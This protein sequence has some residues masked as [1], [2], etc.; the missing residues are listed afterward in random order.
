MW[1]KL[2]SAMP[3]AQAEKQPLTTE[4][5]REQLGRLGGTPFKLG[6]LKNHLDGRRDAAGQRTEPPAPRGGGGAGT[7]ARAA[8]AVDACSADAAERGSAESQS[9]AKHRQTRALDALRLRS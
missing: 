1:R 3:L 5:L 7:P 8:E 2:D 9:T 4:R 6:E